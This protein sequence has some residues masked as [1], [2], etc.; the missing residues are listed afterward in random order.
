MGD[1]SSI[2][3]YNVFGRKFMKTISLFGH[4]RILNKRKLEEKLIKTLKELI[5]QGFSRLLIGC[6]GDFDAIAL[7]TLLNYRN[8][9][10]CN[11]NINVV[12]TSLS[13]LNRDYS[14]YSIIDFYK[15]NN[16]ETVFYDIEE[17]YY[18]NRITFSNRK[19]IDDSDLIVCYVD[20]NSLKSGAKSAIIYAL[21][22]NKRVI[23]LYTGEDKINKT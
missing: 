19:M 8:N 6:H 13:F 16:C 7:S 18:K 22:Q 12:L 14:G 3:C 17:V 2:L 23:N 20:M 9:I 1:I 10:D 15:E 4:R 21:K 5:P 11:I